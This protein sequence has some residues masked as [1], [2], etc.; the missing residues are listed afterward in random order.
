M[1]RRESHRR[2]LSQNGYGRTFII[3]INIIIFNIRRKRIPPRYKR[4]RHRLTE[5]TLLWKTG[6]QIFSGIP[7]ADIL[8]SLASVAISAQ[9]TSL[10]SSPHAPNTTYLLPTEIMAEKRTNDI[11]ATEHLGSKRNASSKKRFIYLLRR[12][13][14]CLDVQRF[15]ETC[16]DL[17]SPSC[18]PRK[19]TS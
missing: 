10:R 8:E 15:A 18:L 2:L 16:L 12:A 9:E 6:L 1:M 17:P 5:P 4:K 7:R 19:P 11:A 13:E 14:T 3:I